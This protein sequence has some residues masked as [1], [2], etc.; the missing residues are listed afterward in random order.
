M[1]KKGD[2]GEKATWEKRRMGRKGQRGQ[3]VV[4]RNVPLYVVR[5]RHGCTN[6]VSRLIDHSVAFLL[7]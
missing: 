2:W 3:K 7:L 4:S 5:G 1:D 6:Q